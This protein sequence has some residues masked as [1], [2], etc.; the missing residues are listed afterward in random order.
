MR[1]FARTLGPILGLIDEFVAVVV[2]GAGITFAVML[3]LGGASAIQVGLVLFLAVV[4]VGWWSFTSNVW[5]WLR[6]RG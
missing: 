4:V 5:Y 2:L 6:R 3:A 1:E